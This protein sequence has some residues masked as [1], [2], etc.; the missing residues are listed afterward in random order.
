M[1]LLQFHTFDMLIIRQFINVS[2]T[3]TFSSHV[4]SRFR[5]FLL[6]CFIR[7][8]VI[9]LNVWYVSNIFSFLFMST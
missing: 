2:G 1:Y 9:P 6:K 3:S 4:I 7:V 5:V 8:F